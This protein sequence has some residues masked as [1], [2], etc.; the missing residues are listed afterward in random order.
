MM[1]RPKDTQKAKRDKYDIARRKLQ[2]HVEILRVLR[3]KRVLVNSTTRLNIKSYNC[4]FGLF[5]VLYVVGCS[6]CSSIVYSTWHGSFDVGSKNCDTACLSGF[7][8]NPFF[9]WQSCLILAKNCIAGMTAN[10]KRLKI[11]KDFG[12]GTYLSQ[13][14]QITPKLQ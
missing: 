6:C 13:C 2:I 9:Q 10:V 11:F 7:L 12:T 1:A 8:A 5:S 3:N 14:L 4:L